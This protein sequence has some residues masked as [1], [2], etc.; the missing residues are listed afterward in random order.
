MACV[1]SATEL[2]ARK[3]DSIVE[4]WESNVVGPKRQV[5]RSIRT[6]VVIDREVEHLWN[7]IV[8]CLSYG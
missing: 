5:R 6:S 7:P 4:V 8:L 1:L 2:I 3:L